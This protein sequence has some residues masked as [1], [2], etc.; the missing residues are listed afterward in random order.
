M[1][2]LLGNEVD[3][4]L[5]TDEIISGILFDIEDEYIYVQ[6]DDAGVFVVVPKENIK[7]YTSGGS[8][9]SNIIMSSQQESYN[10]LPDPPTSYDK[11]PGPNVLSVY[12]DQELIVKIPVPPTFDLNSFN[13]NIMK[14]TLGNPD[15]QAVL[16]DRNQKSV[17]YFPGQIHI[18]TDGGNYTT[19][20]IVN[21]PPQQDSFSMSNSGSPMTSCLSP[22]QMV[23]RLNKVAKKKPEEAEY[24]KNK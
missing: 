13:D 7:Y 15:V 4:F 8:H 5:K 24:D 9:K 14:I 23:S 17:E 18:I 12:V 11:L 22:S 1:K 3:V 10:K 6:S 2:R 21:P 19:P 16:V 20:P